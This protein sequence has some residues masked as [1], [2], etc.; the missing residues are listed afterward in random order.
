MCY[1]ESINTR[2]SG[3]IDLC[4]GTSVRFEWGNEKLV[5]SYSN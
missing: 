5:L 1:I 3:V 4:I 2:S